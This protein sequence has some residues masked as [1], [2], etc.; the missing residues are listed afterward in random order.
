VQNIYSLVARDD[1]PMLDLC[2]GHG[3]AWVPYFPLGGGY[4]TL[5]RV[6]DQQPVIDIAAGIGATPSQVGLAWL[7]AH[8]PASMVISGTSSIAHLDENAAAGDVP[9][10]PAAMTVLDALAASR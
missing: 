1:E 6:A 3:V 8:S 4:G 7:L 9:L 10:D 5:P 2:G